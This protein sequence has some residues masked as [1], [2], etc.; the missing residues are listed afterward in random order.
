MAGNGKIKRKAKRI[1]NEEINK[2]VW[3]WNFSGEIRDTI[4]WLKTTTE[5]W[6]EVLIHW[7]ATYD[8]RHASDQKTVSE[9]IK[10][11]PIL[12]LHNVQEL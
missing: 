12:K 10:D 2:A 3:E 1:G 6:S 11:W 8:L 5:P 7:S 4:E 9:I